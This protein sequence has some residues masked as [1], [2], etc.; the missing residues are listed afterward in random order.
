MTPRVCT[1]ALADRERGLG[2]Q[3]L[4]IE[5]EELTLL[6]HAADGDARRVLGML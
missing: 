3:E 6:A 4:S 1:A 5:D 2:A